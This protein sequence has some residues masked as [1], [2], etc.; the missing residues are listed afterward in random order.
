LDRVIARERIELNR[1]LTAYRQG[2]PALD[3]RGRTTILV[4]DGVATGMTALAAARSLQK[5]G[6]ARVV[7][8]APV[9][10]R[11]TENQLPPDPIDDVVCLVAPQHFVAVGHWYEDFRQVSDDQVV[12][13]I[14]GAGGSSESPRGVVAF[15]HGGSS[16][17]RPR[18]GDR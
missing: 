17:D 15:A 1:R 12:R 16:P 4:D 7:L 6:A 2:R 9:C 11:E 8:A 5:R 14:A 3:V 10:S 13:H 18:G